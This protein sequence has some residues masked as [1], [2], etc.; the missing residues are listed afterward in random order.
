[1]SEDIIM[2]EHILYLNI[3]VLKFSAHMAVP[4]FIRM[5]RKQKREHFKGKQQKDDEERM[6]EFKF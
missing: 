5:T 6:G 1:M 4:Y 2:R 3:E